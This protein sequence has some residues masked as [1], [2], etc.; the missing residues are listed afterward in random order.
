MVDNKEEMLKISHLQ[1]EK[2][3]YKWLAQTMK[4]KN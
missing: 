4:E 3:Y 2:Y 1:I